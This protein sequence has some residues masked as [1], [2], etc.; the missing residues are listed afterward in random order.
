MQITIHAN[1]L[2]I[3][4]GAEQPSPLSE[5]EQAARDDDLNAPLTEKDLREFL[6][7]FVAAITQILDDKQSKAPDTTP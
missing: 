2:H 5:A 7:L 3:H 4:M 1:A 6:P